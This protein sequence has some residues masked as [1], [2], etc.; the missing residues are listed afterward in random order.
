[1]KKYFFWSVLGCCVL[2]AVLFI[3]SGTQAQINSY[4]PCS[5]KTAT[6][7]IKSGLARIIS[8][9]VDIPKK[10]SSLLVNIVKAPLLLIP[11]QKA[12]QFGPPGPIEIVKIMDLFAIQVMNSNAPQTEKKLELQPLCDSFVNVDAIAASSLGHPFKEIKRDP[13][14]KN[15][16]LQAFETYFKNGVFR[17]AMEKFSSQKI[18]ITGQEITGDSAQVNILALGATYSG[19]VRETTPIVLYFKQEG[20]RWKIIDFQ[21]AGLLYTSHNRTTLGGYYDH[22]FNQLITHLEDK[23][24]AEK[25]FHADQNTRINQ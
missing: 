16:Y 10:I 9:G 23:S 21:V 20:A 2:T 5:A 13:D 3:N 22:G 17:L 14:K 25:Q 11:G 1:M 7:N 12:C 15:R 19:Y 8:Q 4:P 24:A 18:K 6:D